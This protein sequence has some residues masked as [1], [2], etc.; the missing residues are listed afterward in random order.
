MND[1]FEYAIKSGIAL[2]V[3]YLFYWLVLRNNTNFRI[4]RMVLMFSLT[5]SMLLPAIAALFRIKSIPGMVLDIN[6]SVPQ[7][8]LPVATDLSN[9][10]NAGFGWNMSR[11]FTA[12]YLAGAIIVMARL[13][14]QAIYLHAVSRLS[15]I[16]EHE[17]FKLVTLDTDMIPFSYF[18]RIFI[19]EGRIEKGSLES[20]I[21]HEK[22]HLRQGH[23]VDLFLIQII[24]V[25]QW[26]NPFVWLFEKSVKE[27]HEYLADE[28][29][30]QSGTNI[31]NY[32]AI[33]VN[34][35]LGGPVFLLT[36]QF[37]QSLIK[38]RIMMMK[39]VKSPKRA[40][41]RALLLIPLFAV[42]LLLFSNPPLISQTGSHEIVV[43]GTVCDYYTKDPIVGANII[44]KNKNIGTVC[45]TL[46]RYEIIV[47]GSE[48]ELVF[49]FM[50]YKTQVMPVGKNSTINVNLEPDIMAIEFGQEKKESLNTE[51][52]ENDKQEHSGGGFVFTETL[53]SFSGGNTVLQKFIQDNIKYPAEA[54]KKGTEGTVLVL[55]VI[56][57]DGK[58]R[59]APQIIRGLS[60]DLDKE[61]I[62]ITVLTEGHWT[63]GNQG[64]RPVATTV[65]MPIEFKM[66]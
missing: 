30:L 55:F 50:G 31:G 56:D 36:N 20:V 4:N 23:Y 48:D 2:S 63:P 19:P 27:V 6:F 42:L 28:E 60:P 40:G 22:S 51:K 57:K 66:K 62:R 64:G 17:G 54:R 32:Q 16:T 49:T 15:K 46:G 9:N 45:D 7:V 8:P 33:L 47:T 29:V 26:F 11:I 5:A 10:T 39:N 3:F 44:I 61:A 25:L 21:R 34:Q 18:N 53:P 14:Y 41:Y 65:T 12:I 58:I 35:A 59:S 52:R 38:K 13:V 1:F 24:S 43:K 37:N